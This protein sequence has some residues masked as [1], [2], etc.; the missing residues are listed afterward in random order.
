MKKLISTLSVVSFLGLVGCSTGSLPSPKYKEPGRITEY[1]LENILPDKYKSMELK[2]IGSVKRN[3]GDHP[4]TDGKEFVVTVLY[5][6]RNR[7]LSLE[8]RGARERTEGD[9]AGKIAAAD[10]S[11]MVVYQVCDGDAN[12]KKP[13]LMYAPHDGE[14]GSSWM[15]YQP[16]D[17]KGKFNSWE[18]LL[19]RLEATKNIEEAK[20]EV[21]AVLP[22]FANC[23]R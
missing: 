9:I 6:D 15:F 21:Q 17:S 13:V 22:T 7:K 23:G 8:E 16:T 14:E 12:N 4:E 3:T 2:Y 5:Q 1:S 18:D 20:K 10:Y 11:I 19:I